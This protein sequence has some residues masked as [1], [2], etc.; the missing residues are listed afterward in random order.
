MDLLAEEL[1]TLL[2]EQYQINIRAI[3][4][5]SIVWRLESE[6]G[7]LCL[8]KVT[9]EEEK[10]HFIC[11]AMDHLTQQNFTLTP[12]VIPTWQG[13]LYTPFQ[14]GFAFLTDWV[15][16]RPCD[17][18]R[19]SH[20]TAAT[21]TL[22][23]FHQHA[24]GLK[25]PQQNH[26]RAYWKRWPRVLSRRTKDLQKYRAL[27][28][29]KKIFLTMT[30]QKKMLAL[31][32]QSIEQ[33]KS[34][35]KILENSQYQEISDNAKKE[36]TFVHRD[37]ASRNFVL[38][39]YNQARLIDFDY[40]RWDIYICDL[41]RL[42]DR[43]LRYYRWSFQRGQEIIKTYDEIRP[44][45][46]AE[47]PLILALLTFPQKFWRLCHRFFRENSV[48]SI[49][50]FLE[51]MKVISSDFASKTRFLHRFAEEYCLGFFSRHKVTIPS[52]NEQTEGEEISQ[53]LEE[54]RI[55]LAYQL[56]L[57]KK[58]AKSTY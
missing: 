11:Q 15:A 58:I 40:C 13:K 18:Q 5:L 1:V 21:A 50:D 6:L 47:Y 17:F 7:P 54:S 30:E 9:Y 51:R 33:A 25:T 19:E 24:K 41:V 43:S 52:L 49:K 57:Y 53:W 4:Q 22:A 26:R 34:S 44:L 28:A 35:L 29:E 31:L 56:G 48:H 8:K 46:P 23:Q 42:L 39:H 3:Q 16:D 14:G 45:E 12:Q 32:D 55:G 37:I 20:L 36:A 27:V 10:L 2:K 38:D